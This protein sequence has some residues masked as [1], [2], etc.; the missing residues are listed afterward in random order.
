MVPFENAHRYSPSPETTA[1]MHM[2][3]WFNHEDGTAEI[4]VFDPHASSN[5]PV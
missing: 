5:C 4:V 2:N 3:R 1:V